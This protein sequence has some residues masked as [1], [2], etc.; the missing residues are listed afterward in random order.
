MST[1]ATASLD[2]L[3]SSYVSHTVAMF[4]FPHTLAVEAHISSRRGAAQRSPWRPGLPAAMQWQT[5]CA[6]P[7]PGQSW[8]ARRWARCLGWLHTDIIAQEGDGTW[9]DLGEDQ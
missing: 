9:A 1:T 4:S 5:P 8:P 6:P 3:H 7:P 2:I